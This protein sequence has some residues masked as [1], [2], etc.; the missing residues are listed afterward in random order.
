[1]GTEA[2]VDRVYA[3]PIQAY[4][5]VLALTSFAIVGRAVATIVTSRAERNE[6]KHSEN[7]TLRRRKRPM[8]A[9][10]G[11]KM[12]VWSSTWTISVLL[13]PSGS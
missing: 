4:S 5:A 7:M 1:M 8:V 12:L 13:S 10:V 9:P 11:S 2:V 6:A 3:L